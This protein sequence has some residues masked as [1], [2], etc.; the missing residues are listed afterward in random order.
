[1]GLVHWEHR[2]SCFF[3]P[4][5]RTNGPGAIS[6]AANI[7][8]ALNVKLHGW[9]I[10]HLIVCESEKNPEVPFKKNV[11][12][13]VN[14]SEEIIGHQFAVVQREKGPSLSHKGDKVSFL[15]QV[16]WQHKK[17]LILLSRSRHKPLAGVS[18]GKWSGVSLFYK[19]Y[20][21]CPIL[22]YIL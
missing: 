14:A 20:H 2:Y 15:S 18:R 6:G 5:V 11:L 8:V 9:E 10:P 7:E 13:W 22:G 3:F 16:Q 19:N 1:M 12:D 21:V 4:Q 17:K